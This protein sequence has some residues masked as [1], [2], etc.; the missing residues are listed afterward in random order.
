MNKLKRIEDED[1]WRWYVK[2]GDAV[3]HQ[4]ISVTE[5]LSCLVPQKL[6]NFF[7]NNSKS[8]VTKIQESTA[9]LGTRIHS[10]IEADLTGQNIML[11]DD[12]KEPFE[13]WLE[14]KEKHSIQAIETELSVY[15]DKLG[16]AGTLDIY[17]LFEGR[18]AIMDIKTGYYD[19]KAGFQMA[20]YKQAFE[21]M[22]G[23][24]GN[25]IVGLSVKRDGSQA[26]AYVYEH[27]NW[28]LKSFIACLEAFKALYFY[29]LDK[30]KWPWLHK[31]SMEILFD[32]KSMA[33]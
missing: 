26:K 25:S 10:I 15:S 12:T 23:E 28:C 3:N 19:V 9:D 30:M 27:E 5:V 29:K 21:E 13:R 8:N 4:Y 7:I 32:G 11:E 18:P 1:G 33:N 14:L 6:K 20:A 24:N 17:G 22:N 31:N 2:D 16:I